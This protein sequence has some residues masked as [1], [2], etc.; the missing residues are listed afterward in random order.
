M[1]TVRVLRAHAEAIVEQSVDA[2]LAST[3]TRYA[4]SGRD[5]LRIRLAELLDTLIEGIATRNATPMIA[6]ASSIASERFADGFELQD[7]QCTINI[8]EAAVWQL[9]ARELPT[10]RFVDAI[11]AV[12]TILGVTK[13]QLARH[14]V[15]LASGHHAPVIDTSALFRGTDG[16]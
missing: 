7:V 11:R 12:S 8:L 16:V 10:D 6:K 9:L 1:D 2:V 13:D 14:Y 4:V 15:A 5:I 3:L